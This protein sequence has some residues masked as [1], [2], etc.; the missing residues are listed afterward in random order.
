[1]VDN[2]FLFQYT[3]NSFASIKQKNINNFK[4]NIVFDYLNNNDYEYALSH[5]EY[6]ITSSDLDIYID[7]KNLMNIDYIEYKNY[8]YSN[9]MKKLEIRTKKNII[10]D[11]LNYINLVPYQPLKNNILFNIEVF[12]IF[13]KNESNETIDNRNDI[14]NQEY[15]NIIITKEEIISNYNDDSKK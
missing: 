12:G 1:M 11:I 8:S 4:Y 15:N 13:V 5:Y 14:I 6:I 2:D 3:N 10:N 7:K 9:L